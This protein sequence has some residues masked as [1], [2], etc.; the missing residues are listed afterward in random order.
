MIVFRG[1]NIYPGQVDEVLSRVPGA[2]SEFQ[3]HFERREDG[4]DHMVLKVERAGTAG[5]AA[6]GALAREV[7]SGI[8]H[9]LMVSCSVEILPYGSLPR[10]DRK[11]RRVFD[12]RSY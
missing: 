5:E 1:V 12:S 10:S 9:N 4:K 2:G 3:V 8:K 6:E 11:T 7:A